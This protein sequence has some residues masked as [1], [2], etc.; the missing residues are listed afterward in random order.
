MFAAAVLALLAQAPAATPW[1]PPS[2]DPRTDPNCS[3]IFAI[4]DARGTTFEQLKGSFLTDSDEWVPTITLPDAEQCRIS[5][6][7]ERGVYSCTWSLGDKTMR[8]GWVQTAD[9]TR[10]TRWCLEARGVKPNLWQNGGWKNVGLMWERNLGVAVDTILLQSSRGT[11]V[12]QWRMKTW[13]NTVDWSDDSGWDF[14][15]SEKGR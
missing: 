8:E 2:Q 1:S 3:D 9:M 4:F 6:E 7:S 14:D 5:L 13:H 12:I 10:M 11:P 15:T